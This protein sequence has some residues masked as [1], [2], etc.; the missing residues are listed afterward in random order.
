[1]AQFHVSH[2]CTASLAPHTGRAANVGA[3]KCDRHAEICQLHDRRST[4]RVESSFSGSMLRASRLPHILP[5]SVIS[6]SYLG[7]L[8]RDLDVGFRV[9]LDCISL[10]SCENAAA[11][12]QGFRN[13][14]VLT[15]H[16]HFA[17]RVCQISHRERHRIELFSPG[18]GRGTPLCSARDAAGTATVEPG[19][20]RG[21]PRPRAR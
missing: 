13:L 5:S 21:R 15:T 4:H 16:G 2:H 17:T 6:T 8:S 18:S 14:L 1:M 10:V 12:R 7:I 20:H 9:H 11:G 3:T 19:R